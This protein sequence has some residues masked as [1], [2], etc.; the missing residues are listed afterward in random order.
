MK[1]QQQ[2]IR[3][4]LPTLPGQSNADRRREETTINNPPRKG[5][6]KAA[7]REWALMMAENIRMARNPNIRQ[8]HRDRY[9]IDAG[10]YLMRAE[11]L[12]DEMR[13]GL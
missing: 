6:R 9:L 13:G 12:R 2:S 5:W 4:A 8:E 3:F 1:T 11:D 10:R 7:M